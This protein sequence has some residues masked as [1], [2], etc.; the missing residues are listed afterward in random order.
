MVPLAF[1][2]SAV[3]A[4]WL[5][6]PI[7]MMGGVA[8]AALYDLAMRS[9]PPGLQG[10]LMMMIDGVY[11]LSYRAGDLVGARIYAS[12]PT[13]GFLYCVIATT[14]VYAL[15]LPVILLIPKEIIATADGERNPTVEAQVLAEI[16]DAAPAAR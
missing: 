16:G 9:C 5:A 6:V 8:A 2:H 11:Q 10:A 1:I 4:L 12:S 15:M 7:G 13:H 14:T 3:A